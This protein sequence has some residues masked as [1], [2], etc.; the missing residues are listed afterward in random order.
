MTNKEWLATLSNEQFSEILCENQG[1]LW[2]RECIFNHNKEHNCMACIAEW[3]EL[4]HE[5]EEK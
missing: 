1:V 5:E 3:L 4:E 2:C